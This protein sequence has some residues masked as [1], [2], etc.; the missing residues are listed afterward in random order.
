MQCMELPFYRPELDRANIAQDTDR[1]PTD[2]LLHYLESNELAESINYGAITLAIIRPGM[3]TATNQA[4]TDAEVAEILESHIEEL[5]I[6]AK[7]SMFL[8][9]EAIEEFYGQGPKQVMATKAPERESGHASKWEEFKAAMQDG[10]VT[11]LLLHSPLGDAPAKWREQVGH[12][13]VEASR[14]MRTIRGR[15]A[16][17]SYNNLVHGSDTPEAVTREIDILA[18]NLKRHEI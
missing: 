11:V 7:F 14:D 16:L 17:S 18:R 10:P 3:D 2:E 6:A 9:D 5:G 12:R 13:D 15:F 4:G 1:A 8:D